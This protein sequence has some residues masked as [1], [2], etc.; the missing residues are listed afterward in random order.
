MITGIKVVDL[1]APYARGGKIG[2][3]I[4]PLITILSKDFS[5]VLVSEKLCSSKNLSITSLKLMV[6]TQSSLASERE[7]ERVMIFTMK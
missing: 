7:P 6:V 5:V 3:Q 1:L 4:P 2:N